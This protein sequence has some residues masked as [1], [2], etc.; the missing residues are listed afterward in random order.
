MCHASCL[1]MKNED[2][3]A[4]FGA[5]RSIPP[6]LYVLARFLADVYVYICFVGPKIRLRCARCSMNASSPM[7]DRRV[8]K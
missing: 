2:L 6:V 7:H 1:S 4:S 3:D 8:L 5:V